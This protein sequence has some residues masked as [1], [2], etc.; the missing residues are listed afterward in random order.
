MRCRA[1]GH[2]VPPIP[3]PQTTI[4]VAIALFFAN[5]CDGVEMVGWKMSAEP[6]PKSTPW[7]SMNW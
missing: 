7:A 1:I 5:H 2:S 3:E 4:A 6:R